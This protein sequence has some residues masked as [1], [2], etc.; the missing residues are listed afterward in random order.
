MKMIII[1]HGETDRNRD[2]A[3]IGHPNMPMNSVGRQQAVLAAQSLA[4]EKIDIIYSSDLLRAKETAEFISAHH[5][6]TKIILD[7]ELRE[8]D[9]G[10]FAT[11]PTAEHQ[12]AQKAS[13][14][15][16]RDWKPKGGE[17]LR[18]VKKRAG[19]WYAKHCR[20]DA[21]KS[22]VVVSHGLFIYSL[23]EWA[24]EDG[25]DVERQDFRHSN[26]GITVLD[27][28]RAG[29]TTVIHLNNTKHLGGF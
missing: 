25:A 1:R 19:H 10:E 26:A 16:F 17:S 12:A 24:I 4:S 9:S 27:I 3:H 22:I 13:D 20:S 29:K 7:P 8:R 11:Q 14:L 5:T 15:D 28:P 23:L 2:G 6:E 21:D 18:E